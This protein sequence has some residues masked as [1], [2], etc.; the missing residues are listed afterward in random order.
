MS[1]YRFFASDREMPEIHILYHMND[2]I[3]VWIERETDYASQY[4]DK[5][6]IN[7]IEWNYS[8]KNAQIILDYIKELL[9]DR[10]TVELFDTW[11]GDK[12]PVERAEVNISELTIHDIKNIWKWNDDGFIRNRCLTVFKSRGDRYYRKKKKKMRIRY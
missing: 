5:K 9:E 11:M 10:F 2:S 4:T 12:T 7:Y 8:D 1:G 3:N 6:Y